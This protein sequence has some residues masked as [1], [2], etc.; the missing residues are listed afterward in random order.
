[1]DMRIK[2][3]AATLQITGLAWVCAELFSD[4]E[5]RV[6]TLTI[7]ACVY[8]LPMCVVGFAY[9]SIVRRLW[10]TGAGADGEPRRRLHLSLIHI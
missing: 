9:G 7:Y 5:R 8:V 6:Y 3:D 10:R 1:M 2:R 4:R